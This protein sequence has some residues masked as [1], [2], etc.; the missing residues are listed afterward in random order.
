MQHGTSVLCSQIK[1]CISETP[2][3]KYTRTMNYLIVA[4]SL[5]AMNYQA[6]FG[7]TT[8]SSKQ[9][10]PTSVYFRP[11]RDQVDPIISATAIIPKD[12]THRGMTFANGPNAALAALIIKE[13][14]EEDLERKED[15]LCDCDDLMECSF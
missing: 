8:S 9:A 15:D 7:F 1:S 4:L 6:C 10:T 14:C 13:L 11:P 2:P 5:L 3:N 12:D